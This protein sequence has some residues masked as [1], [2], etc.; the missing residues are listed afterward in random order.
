MSTFLRGS[1]GLGGLSAQRGEH[2]L[3]HPR[4][5]PGYTPLLYTHPRGIPGLYTLYI[6]HPRGIPGLYTTYYTPPERHTRLYHPVY[7]PPE[8]HT[9]VYTTLYIHYPR[10]IPGCKPPYMPP[11]HPF[12]GGET[13]LYA[14]LLPMV[15]IPP[16]VYA[17]MW[18][19]Q[20]VRHPV[21]RAPEGPSSRCL[22][23]R[24][25]EI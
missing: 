24:L 12:V 20:C 6:Q 19:Q 3:T 9:R 17:R 5:I 16:G 13:S 8:R 22:E 11:Y 2:S 25:W 18:Y 15:G 23:S 21:G 4:G 7:T 1:K 10:G 14:S